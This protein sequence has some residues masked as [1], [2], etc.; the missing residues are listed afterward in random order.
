MS[1]VQGLG[2][3]GYLSSA[4]QPADLT[5]T[6]DGLGA[7]YMSSFTL[8]STIE[9]LGSYGYISSATGGGI[10]PAD[11]VSSVQGLGTTGYLSSALQLADLTSTIDGLG[12]TYVSS[13]TLFSTIEGLGSYGYISSATGGGIAPADLVSTVS[14]LGSEGYL[15]SAIQPADITSTIDGLGATYMSSF[16][17]FSTVEGLGSY[18]YLSTGIQMAVLESTV[19]GLGTYG[20]LSTI[21]AT[22]PTG[23]LGVPGDLGATGPTGPTGSTGPTG[24]VYTPTGVWSSATAY[25]LRDLAIDTINNN[26]YVCI[27]ASTNNQPSTEPT[28]WTELVSKGPT[29]PTGPAPL[30]PMPTLAYYLSANIAIPTVTDT[31]VVFDTADTANTQGT[32]GPTYSTSTG[33][34]TNGTGNTVTILVSA[35]AAFDVNTSLIIR[36]VKNGSSIDTYT[37]QTVSSTNIFTSGSIVMAPSDTLQIN[38]NQASGS[39]ANITGDAYKFTRVVFTQLDTVAGPTGPTGPAQLG[40]QYGS[41]T[42]DGVTFLLAVA[43]T[44]PFASAPNVTATVND[45]SASF[46]SVG[47]VTTTGFTA[48]T[49]NASGGVS[50]GFNWQAML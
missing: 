26:T 17:L 4:L 31:I 42:T 9:G 22:G 32:F 16:T 3:T 29:G 13:F 25:N 24:T 41:G 11:L 20:Y 44:T 33:I 38:V 34:L 47:S 5:S 15:S 39:G 43:F 7:T 6:I 27:Q 40:I 8:F 12:G 19:Q 1:S 30:R 46:A 28:Y 48:Y 35:Q 36:V 2:T 23:P 14:G 37:T 10:A 49:W 50:A 18:G 45:A 21:G